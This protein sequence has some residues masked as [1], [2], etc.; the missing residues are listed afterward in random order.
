M[1]K[2]ESF[3]KVFIDE[4]RDNTIDIFE[5]MFDGRMKGLTSQ[6]VQEKISVFDEQQKDTVLW[7]LSK[8]VD[9]SMHNML[10]MIEEHEEINIIYDTE[11]IEE[12][13]DGLSGELYTEDGWIEKYSNKP[14]EE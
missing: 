13:S 4:V 14:Y 7:I 10:F 8:A 11:D 9:Q 1:T 6:I 5:K 12:R 2:L 3:G